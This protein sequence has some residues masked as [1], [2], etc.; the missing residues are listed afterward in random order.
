M[1]YLSSMTSSSVFLL[2]IKIIEI[3]DTYPLFE[4]SHRFLGQTETQLHG[5]FTMTSD[6]VVPKEN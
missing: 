5:V 3:Y 4:P 6:A 2:T 1:L